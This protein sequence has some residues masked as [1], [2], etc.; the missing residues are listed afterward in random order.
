MFFF[1]II[2]KEP[3][4]SRDF[5]NL[6]L[7]QSSYLSDIVNDRNIPLNVRV[8]M[9]KE[10][11]IILIAYINLMNDSFKVTGKIKINHLLTL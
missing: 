3:N 9:V 8:K 4:I 11:Y 6:Y 7:H 10:I 5:K 2:H 1:K